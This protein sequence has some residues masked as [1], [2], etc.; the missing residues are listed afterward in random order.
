GYRRGVVAARGELA[1]GGDRGVHGAG[2][3][4]A[5]L[6]GWAA[7]RGRPD[8]SSWV[9]YGP[10]LGAGLLPTV[11]LVLAGEAAPVRRLL[12]GAVALAT[13]LWGVR[14]ARQA[15]VVLGGASL[16]AVTLYELTQLAALLPS[17]VVLGAGGAVLLF[18]AVTVERRRRDLTRLAAA[19]R[20]MR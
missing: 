9:A 6:C 5:L 16:A 15:P 3:G 7:L 18:C 13:V 14:G 10:G 8:L 12:V 11:A 19:L 17:W 2:G 4:A 1:A 20:R